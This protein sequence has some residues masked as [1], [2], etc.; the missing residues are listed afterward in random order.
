[1]TKLAALLA[2]LLAPV[3]AWAQSAAE[4]H[5]AA[6]PP[7][8]LQIGC[9]AEAD[10]A[11]LESAG[12]VEGEL[13]RCKVDLEGR[14]FIRNDHPNRFSASAINN[15]ATALTEL[16]AAP[17]AGLSIYITDI[18]ASASVAATV[19]A[20]Q[21][22]VLKYGTGANCATGTTVVW[23]SYNTAMGAVNAQFMTPIKL[24]ANNALCWMHAAVGS[25]SF[26]VNG[27]IAP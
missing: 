2:L 8:A 15:A 1:M 14:L 22:L 4:L 19:T 21:Y 20:D 12:V 5:G 18:T 25:K 9:Y 23:A 17:G 3:A 27:Y 13:S 24:P 16:R 10:A 26:I 7:A 11:A 6:A